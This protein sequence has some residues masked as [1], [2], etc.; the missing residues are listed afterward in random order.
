MGRILVEDHNDRA[1]AASAAANAAWRTANTH[2]SVI[3]SDVLAEFRGRASRR[4]RDD[5]GRQ[6]AGFIAARRRDAAATDHTSQPGRE[7][8]A[9]PLRACP[10]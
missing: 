5:L 10:H 4:M 1:P 2:V 3:E 9:P 8:S 6:W 7:Q